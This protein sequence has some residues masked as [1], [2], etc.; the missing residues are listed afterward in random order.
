MCIGCHKEIKAQNKRL[1]MSGRVLK[2]RLPN[3]GPS[4]CKGCHIEEE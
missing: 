1:E 4:S 3:P 2:D